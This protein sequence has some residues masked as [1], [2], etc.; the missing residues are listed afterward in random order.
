MSSNPLLQLHELGQS[1]WLDQFSRA[2]VATGGL[3]RLIDEDGLCGVTS[4]PTIFQKAI[5]GSQDYAEQLEKLARGGSNVSH[6]YED[7]VLQ[8]IGNGADVLR[9]A[10]DASNGADGFISLEVSPLLANDT[11]ATIEEAKRLFT[12][13][14]RPNVMIFR[15]S[16]SCCSPA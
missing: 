16:R 4:N 13:L 1:V 9:G 5:S 3:K 15:P 7:L 6:I 12:H 10:Y 2:L 11:K 14:N 8:D